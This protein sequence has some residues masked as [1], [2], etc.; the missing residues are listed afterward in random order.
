MIRKIAVALLAL[1]IV[2]LPESAE[3]APKLSLGPVANPTTR[4]SN[5]IGLDEQLGKSLPLDLP[6]VDQAGHPVKLA[7][8]FGDGKPV[9][10]VLA[11]FRCPMLCDLVLRGVA[12][13]L[14]AIGWTLGKQYRALTVSIDPRDS[15]KA[16]LHKQ[17][18]LLQALGEPERARSWPFLVGAEPQI[19]AL[20]ERVGFQYVYDPHTD[21]Y[22]HPACAIVLTPD[23]HISRYLYGVRF[24]TRDLRLAMVEA[25][26]GTV[27][28]II[29]RLIL[30]CFR[31]DPASHRYA[32]YVTAVMKGGATLVLVLVA[33]MVLFLWRLERRRRN[34]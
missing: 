16:A 34:A 21:E 32:I 17:G 6:F 18:A 7:D 24:P 9:V 4:A 10:L 23:G 31:Y 2:S 26:H 28:S 8:Y 19:H 20:A 29:D 1:A 25:S 33:G 11:Y 22:A 27:G 5:Q 12:D 13:G 15:A 14:R 3:A 30:C